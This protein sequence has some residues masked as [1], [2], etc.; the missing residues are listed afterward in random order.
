MKGG[1]G[2]YTIIRAIERTDALDLLTD[3]PR[4]FGTILA[5][6]GPYL[7]IMGTQIYVRHP[8]QDALIAF[9]TDAEPSVH[10][11]PNPENRVNLENPD[12]FSSQPFLHRTRA[13]FPAYRE[14]TNTRSRQTPSRKPRNRQRRFRLYDEKCE[15]T[16]HIRR[17]PCEQQKTAKIVG[18]TQGKTSFGIM[19]AV[20]APEYAQIQ[21]SGEREG[22]TRE[23]LVEPLTNYFVGRVTQDV[24]AGNSRIGVITTAVN[25]QASRQSRKC[26]K[27]QRRFRITQRHVNPP[28]NLSERLANNRKADWIGI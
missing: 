4:T 1:T 19:E 14:A 2:A 27:R 12:H 3:H 23:H 10:Q 8:E 25:R 17:T 6:M 9:H 7:Q 22:S 18:R 16:N 13:I 21:P 26:R 5:L 15:S 11:K 20:T 28:T 24:L